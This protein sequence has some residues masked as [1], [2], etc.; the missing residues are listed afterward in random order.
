MAGWTD[1]MAHE[2][3]AFDAE[4]EKEFNSQIDDVHTLMAHHLDDDAVHELALAYVRAADPPA[5]R[6]EPWVDDLVKQA[7][8]SAA[9]YDSNE[10]WLK[11]QGLYEDLSLLE[12]ADPQ[13]KDDLKLVTRRIGALALYTPDVARSLVDSEVKDRQA[14]QL[15]LHPATQPAEAAALQDPLKTG[16]AA[17]TTAPAEEQAKSDAD[18]WK[19]SLRGVSI[20]T[21]ESALDDAA[22]N[23]YRATTFTDLTLGGI[24][25]LRIIATTHGLD[26]EFAALADP[27]KQASFVKA[28][29]DAAAV[30]KATGNGREIDLHDALNHLE[31]VNN[32]TIKLPD[33]VFAAEFA[34]GALGTLDPFSTMIWPHD[35][36]GFTK[37]TQGTFGGVGIQIQSDEDGSLRVITPLED[38]PADRAGIQPDDV[39]SRINGKSA[40]GITIDQAV[41]T[42]SGKP[43]EPVTLTIQSPNGSVKDHTIVREEIKVQSVKGYTHLPSGGW[44][45]Y[46]DPQEK[47]AYV[48]LTSFTATSFDEMSKALSDLNHSGARGIILDLR[49]N[50]GGLLQAAAAICNEF[51]SDGI[52]V[53]THP[54]RETSNQPTEIDARPE[55]VECTLPMVILVNQYSASASEIVSGCLKDHRRALIVGERTFGKGSVQNLYWLGNHD[56]ELKLTTAHYYLPNGKCIHREENST[57][58]GVDPDIKVQM[59][60][61]QMKTAIAARQTMDVLHHGPTTQPGPD[62]LSV[63]SQLA[64]GLL[65]LRLEV[66]DQ[67]AVAALTAGAN[68]PAQP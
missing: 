50:P 39:I 30:A 29:D 54:D 20:D 27:A 63:D 4:R 23:Y 34:S 36:A 14:A 25:G 49:N 59:T 45:F 5:F 18:S 62:L 60:P 7:A 16:V 67:S 68:V 15:V 26:K 41:N 17:P 58:W 33:E 56:T 9:R 32:Q 6:K 19:D 22:E 46:V 12:P 2:A 1:S 43:G 37:L 31:S 21:V 64:A 57:T 40:K 51:I 44:N 10:Q 66:S 11:A 42:I 53:S 61:D 28:L 55:R 24:S 35:V 13:W 52:I 3:A 47:I 65:V 38:S 8:A 48:H